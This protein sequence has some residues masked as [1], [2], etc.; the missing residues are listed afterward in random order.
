M[1]K[2]QQPELARSGRSETDPAA[3]KTRTGGPTD[4]TAPT[5]PIPEDNLPGHHP[6]HDQD[7]PDGPPPRPRARKAATAKATAKVTATATKTAATAVDGPAAATISDLGSA[8]SAGPGRAPRGKAQ[9]GFDF[10]RRLTPFAFA[11]GITP[12]TS[13]VEVGDGELRVRFGPWTV[14]TPLANVEGAQVTGPYSSWK[15]AGP[16]HL[17]LA[18]RGVT[19]ATST[20]QGVCIRF[21]E[22]VSALAPKA[23]FRHPALTVTVDDAAGLVDAL[24]AR[25]TSGS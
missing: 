22:P 19:F 23:L 11:L 9:F 24:E 14:R 3:A 10:E 1:T 7:K 20:R 15:V 5:G 25:V 16:P 18:D 4:Q 12:F 6:E 21:K 8:R 2:P 13:G 17:S